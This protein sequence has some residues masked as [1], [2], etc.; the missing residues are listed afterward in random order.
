MITKK[1]LKKNRKELSRH[2]DKNG[3]APMTA[4]AGTISPAGSDSKIS[5]FA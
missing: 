4:A 2:N 5:T 1:R 3:I